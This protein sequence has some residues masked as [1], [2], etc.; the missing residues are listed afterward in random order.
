M[1]PCKECVKCSD[2]RCRP[3]GTCVVAKVD[4]KGAEIFEPQ[5]VQEKP[6]EF[7]E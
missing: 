6:K 7:G 4:W 5:I 1:A 3:S 2:S